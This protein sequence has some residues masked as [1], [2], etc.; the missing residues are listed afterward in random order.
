MN[1]YAAKLAALGLFF[2][3]V[4]GESIACT[5]L[6]ASFYYHAGVDIARRHACSNHTLVISGGPICWTGDDYAWGVCSEALTWVVGSVDANEYYMD[7]IGADI[8]GTY[9]VYMIA[10]NE[11]DSYDSDAAYYIIVP[12]DIIDF[13]FDSYW[14]EGTTLVECWVWGSNTG[15][16]EDLVNLTVGEDL[17]YPG[18]NPYHPPD[19]PFGGTFY[20]GSDDGV[21][22][23]ATEGYLED[24]H[25]MGTIRNP[26]GRADTY[27]VQQT[28]IRNS[29]YDN[30]ASLAGPIAIERTVQH[31]TSH[32]SYICDCSGS[33]ANGWMSVDLG[34]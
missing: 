6:D 24:P 9:V 4:G 1:R 11:W 28:Y 12:M 18:P 17:Q 16:L 13:E 27:T 20:S 14:Q 33:G 8:P 3:V 23:A 29:P 5:P 21:V 30:P 2:V 15:K 7:E 10:C 34:P 26:P 22:W 19:P 32:W 31:V 25:T